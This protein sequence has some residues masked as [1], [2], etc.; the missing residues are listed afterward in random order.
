MVELT[1]QTLITPAITG[2]VTQTLTLSKRL[3]VALE[4]QMFRLDFLTE[5]VAATVHGIHPMVLEA[6]VKRHYR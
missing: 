3:M 4:D 2:Q 5:K 1:L 6:A